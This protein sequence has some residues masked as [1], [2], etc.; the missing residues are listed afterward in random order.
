MTHIS[1]TFSLEGFLEG[2][3][4]ETRR[5]KITGTRRRERAR[6]LFFTAK[7]LS[8]MAFTQSKIIAGYRE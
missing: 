3:Q 1:T 6:I 2:P 8:F 5:P 7:P 4:P